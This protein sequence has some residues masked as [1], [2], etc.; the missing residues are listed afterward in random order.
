MYYVWFA[1]RC[2]ENCS[3]SANGHQEFVDINEA[4]TLRNQPEM[5]VVP[6]L[7]ASCDAVELL[8]CSVGFGVQRVGSVTW[9]SIFLLFDKI[10]A[11]LCPT[12]GAKE[13][14]PIRTCQPKMRV[15]E[16]NADLSGSMWLVAPVLA[17]TSVVD[18]LLWI[19]NLG[20]RCAGT[21]GL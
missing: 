20:M 15:Y 14:S 1:P 7:A 3:V 10:V 2:F 12:M 4:T 6:E 5:F 13:L 18:F 8:S 19:L 17:T 16:M 21:G 9:F 11:V